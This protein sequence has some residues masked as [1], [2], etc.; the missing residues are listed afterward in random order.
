MKTRNEFFDRMYACCAGCIELRVIK[1]RQVEQHFFELVD[2]ESISACCENYKDANIYFGVG[3]RDASGQ[4]KKEN[5]VNTPALWVDVDFKDIAAAEVKKRLDIFPFK[6]SAAVLTGHGVHFYWI[7]REPA[8]RGDFERIEDLLRRIAQ[9][10]NGD[11]SACEVARVLRVPGSVNVKSD[12]VSVKLHYLHDFSYNLDDFDVLP[13][14]T[15]ST[16][17]GSNGKS[18]NPPGWMVKAFKGVPEGGN[19]CFAG[20]D[21]TGIKLAG[22]WIDKLEPEETFKILQCWNVRNEPPLK[23]NDLRRILNSASKYKNGE[24]QNVKRIGLSFG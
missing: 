24:P 23:E 15:T 10:V 7:L 2:N 12:P 17:I 20:R 1:N 22:Y 21:A 19:D 4:G 3:T 16:S 13:E 5:V 18:P 8:E 9:H 11:R 6:P 14:V